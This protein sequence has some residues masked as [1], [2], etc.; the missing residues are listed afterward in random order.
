M[1]VWGGKC[2]SEWYYIWLLLFD[3]YELVIPKDTR[4]HTPSVCFCSQTFQLQTRQD[5]ISNTCNKQIFFFF[6]FSLLPLPQYM[7]CV[8][9]HYQSDDD[10]YHCCTLKESDGVGGFCE[11]SGSMFDSSI[12]ACI[13]F[14]V[15]ISWRTVIP[16]FG[17]DQ[18]TV[19]QRAVT[20]V[21]EC[22]LTSCVW[23]RFRIRSHTL[24]GQRH[25]QPTSTSLG[26]RRMRV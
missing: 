17:Q 2:A 19:A 1:S 7:H 22:S 3:P 21:T 20:T 15:E 11:N 8:H 24:P 16:L 26:Q 10:D 25:S 5:V 18:S 13:F 14:K 4:L 6:F 12:A 9:D 23:A